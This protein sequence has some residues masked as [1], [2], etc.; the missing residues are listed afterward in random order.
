MVKWETICLPKEVGGL[1]M[2]NTKVMYWC[3]IAKW[4]WKLLQGQGGPRIQI[5]HNK[6]VSDGRAKLIRSCWK[7]Q[8]A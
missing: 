8:F 2:I 1:G 6:Y 5:F 4:A 3:L 7:S